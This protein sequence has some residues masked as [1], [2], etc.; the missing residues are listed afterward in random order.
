[1]SDYWHS[2][3]NLV[4][5]QL[6]GVI[7]NAYF[8][9]LA[10]N[11]ALAVQFKAQTLKGLPIKTIVG[12]F[13]MIDDLGFSAQQQGDGPG[14]EMAAAF[15]SRLKNEFP[16]VFNLW[17]AAD[18]GRYLD[19]IGAFGLVLSNGHKIINDFL[20]KGPE[21][22]S[23]SKLEQ[24]RDSAVKDIMSLF[25]MEH[26]AGDI[27]LREFVKAE[28]L[29]GRPAWAGPSIYLECWAEFA[30]AVMDLSPKPETRALWPY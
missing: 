17:Q 3:M 27:D 23:L 10:V 18:R 15:F 19:P 5:E 28:G 22:I 30:R 20:N 16:D 9:P 25:N 8:V 1:M 21:E 26:D 2:E 6:D 11:D 24:V 29:T 7:D 14:P 12:V 13:E 4:L